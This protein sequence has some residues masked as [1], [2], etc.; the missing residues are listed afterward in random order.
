M[1]KQPAM[2]ERNSNDNTDCSMTATLTT[3]TDAPF[4]ATQVT[5]G[6]DLAFTGTTILRDGG[7]MIQ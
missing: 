2:D 3:S 7:V 1:T 6:L 5:T 4:V